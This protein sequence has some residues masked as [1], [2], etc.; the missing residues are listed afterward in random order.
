MNSSS[1]DPA[2]PTLQIRTAKKTAAVPPSTPAAAAGASS[3]S[4]GGVTAAAGGVGGG[5]GSPT[6]VLSPTRSSRPG[7]ARAVR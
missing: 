4:G 5:V 1:M 3:S 6:G 2:L 7:S